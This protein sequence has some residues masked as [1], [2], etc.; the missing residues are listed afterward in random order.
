MRLT[1]SE[2]AALLPC[3]RA[4]GS[5][6]VITGVSIDS[7]TV[8]PGDLFFALPGEHGDGHAYV[9]AALEAGAAAAVV[10]EGREDLPPGAPLLKTADVPEA[11][12]QLASAYRARFTVPVIAITGSNG[13]TTTKNMIVQL[14]SGRY[15]VGGT[16]GNF[17]N[18]IGLPLSICGWDEEI[19]IGVLE[20]G[21]N[22]FGEIAELCRIAR[23]THGLIT[24]IGKGHLEYFH[25]LEGVARAKG[26]LLAW[27]A[28]AGTAF[29]NTDDP[30]LAG[31]RT[32][33][34]TTV[35]YGSDDHCD[36]RIS[37]IRMENGFPM[38]RIQGRMVRVPVPG[39]FSVM[40]AAAAA[41]VA[42]FFDIPWNDIVSG[43][44]GFVP[45]GR[46]M[47]MVEAGGVTILNDCYNANPTSMI[48]ALSAL[49]QM[50]SFRRRI[51]VLGDMAEVGSGSA[52][53]HAMLGPMIQ[54]NGCDAFF[55][56]GPEMR[57]AAETAASGGMKQVFRFDSRERLLAALIDFADEGDIL[58]VKASRSMRMEEITGGL[59][60]HLRKQR[61][62]Y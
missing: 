4:G 51:A 50:T 42:G 14:L 30:L 62:E 8:R 29:L 55:A 9:P 38:V 39:R 34:A 52:E 36:V 6:P 2:I 56:L 16:P 20:M 26:E 58:L 10:G 13:K 37:D 35:T 43:I 32:V 61:G 25:D 59:V 31:M 57:R 48:G 23:P 1:L 3:R 17:N 15:R 41:A 44:E 45:A 24:N 5:D 19:E 40:N 46:R 27:L 47:E 12:R 18:T 54:V 53:E 33:A 7:R 22:H 11:L 60:S 21:T 49:G 28:P